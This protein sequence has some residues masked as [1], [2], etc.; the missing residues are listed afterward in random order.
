MEDM[1]PRVFSIGPT[2]PGSSMALDRQ[3]QPIVHTNGGLGKRKKRAGPM[4]R[5]F[6]HQPL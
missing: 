5:P 4:A 6:H 3:N 2:P 1:K